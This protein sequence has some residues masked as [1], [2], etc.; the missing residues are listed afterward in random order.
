MR[1]KQVLY[2]DKTEHQDLVVFDSHAW[3]RVLALDGVVQTT[4]AD[5]FVYHEMLVHVPVLAHGDVEELL[6]IGG[7]D[8]GSLARGAAPSVDP[9]RHPGR[10]RRRRHRVL[11]GA[12]CRA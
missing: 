11:Q 4:T 1:V 6:I 3:G 10:D 9:P 12:T 2:R 8:G 7:G 5:E